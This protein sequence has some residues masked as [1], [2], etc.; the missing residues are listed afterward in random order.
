VTLHSEFTE[1]PA[2]QEGLRLGEELSAA[3]QR[4]EMAETAAKLNSA[5]CD[6]QRREIA[7]LTKAV[8]ERDITIAA[9]QT[10]ANKLDSQ[11]RDALRERDTLKDIVDGAKNSVI[12]WR[13]K[14]WTLLA[15]QE[16]GDAD[17]LC[18]CENVD[19]PGDHVRPF[20]LEGEPEDIR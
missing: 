18:W 13:G 12:R 14:N 17:V 19:C 4:V 11:L 16:S 5:T 6:E 3:I 20:D 2:F 9:A 8:R 7:R 10:L 15:I 1:H